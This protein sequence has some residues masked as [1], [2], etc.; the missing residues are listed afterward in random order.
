MPIL[1]VLMLVGLVSVGAIQEYLS[2]GIRNINYWGSLLFI[3]GWGL[4]YVLAEVDHLFYAWM[5]N[6]Q[7]LSCLRVRNEIENRRFRNAWAML[8]ATAHER[9]RLPIHNVFTGLIVAILGVW[10]I[11]STGNL[12]ASGLVISL[13]LKLYLEFLTDVDYKRWY[14]IIAREFTPTEHK[15]VK[16]VWGLLI[17]GQIWNLV[18]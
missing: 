8:K 17:A 14:W 15:V 16:W 18:R 10:M 12:L 1:N 3:V 2:G 11:S 6:P 7:E 5:C 13:S 4:G 9:T